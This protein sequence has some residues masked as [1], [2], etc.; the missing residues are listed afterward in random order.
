MAVAADGSAL[1]V[2]GETLPDGLTHVFARR[3]YET[4]LS[5]LPQD[6]SLAGGAAD[7]PEV[8]IEFD[9]S[10]AWV[11]FRQTIDGQS[12]TFA[13]RLRASTFEVPFAL[14]RGVASAQP[15][16]SMSSGGLGEAVSVT[17]GGLLYGARLRNDVFGTA[18]RSDS[19]G[20]RVDRDGGDLRAQRLRA[21]VARRRRP[22]RAGWRPSAR[23]SAGRRCSPAPRSDL[24]RPASCRRPRTG[25]ATWRSPS[26]RARRAGSPSASRCTTTR[27]AGRRCARFR[28]EVG[29]RPLIRWTPGQEFVGPQRFRVLIDGRVVKTTPRTSLRLKRLR[30]GTHRVQ[31]VA[32]DRRGQRS[33]VSRRDTFRVR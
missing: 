8:D 5:V 11:A 16:L 17:S 28:S 18:A 29:P 24:R 23:A 15:H 26:S 25:S 31:V 21:A 3:I 10:Y 13:R 7:S 14:D 22:S 9:R 27:R 32:V 12:R 1:V 4:T 6:A 2:W 33:Q 20:A 30:G 19:G